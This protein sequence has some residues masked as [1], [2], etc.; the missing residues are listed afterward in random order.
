MGRGGSDRSVLPEP[1]GVDVEGQWGFDEECHIARRQSQSFK[2]T[3]VLCQTV[4]GG[5]PGLP[6]DC[7]SLLVGSCELRELFNQHILLELGRPLACYVHLAIKP[8]TIW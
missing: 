3:T 8:Q 6:Q 5:A 1:D 2:Q 4:D 7:V